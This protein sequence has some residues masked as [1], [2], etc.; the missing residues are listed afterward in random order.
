MTAA[1]IAKLLQNV[2]FKVELQT[3]DS[4]LL[5]NPPFWRMDIAIA[6]DIV[7]EVGRLFGYDKLPQ[8]L[9]NRSLKPVERNNL[10]DLKATI[11]KILSGAGANEVL[12]YSFVHGNT[13]KKAG[14]NPE[15]AF[16]LGNALS[17][18]L[19]YYRLSLMPSLLEKVHSNIKAGFDNFAL[20]EMNKVHIKDWLDDEKLPKE[21]HRLGFVYVDSNMP[22]DQSA[23]YW[24]LNYV[25]ELL[26]PIRISAEI[27]SLPDKT[28]LAIK[29]QLVAPFAKERT[30]IIVTASGE[31]LGVVGEFKPQV[32]KE[33]K[34]PPF[35][36]GFELDLDVLLENQEKVSD[37]RSL[38][39][40][41]KVEQD[42]TLQVDADMAYIKVMQSL[43]DVIWKLT[44]DASKNNSNRH[45]STR[46]R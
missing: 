16:A 18:D 23:Y 14:Q 28:E 11:R 30:A 46:Y 24:A 21:E 40:Y 8:E 38:A 42:I 2:E 44:S 32:A 22:K 20:F 13:F 19:Q 12:T 36:V 3:P 33:F 41:P 43:M 4:K 10:F 1:E 6:E 15:K 45:L 26:G 34:L 31:L 25:A 9:P 37:Y 5:I 7:E 17:P 39:R 35:C 29:E 27:I